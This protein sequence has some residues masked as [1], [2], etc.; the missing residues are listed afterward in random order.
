[1]QHTGRK[2]LKL[3]YIVSFSSF[4]SRSEPTRKEVGGRHLYIN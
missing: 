2:N 4:L 1:M 3:K